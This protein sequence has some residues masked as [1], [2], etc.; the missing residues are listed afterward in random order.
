[1]QLP[2]GITYQQLA[3]FLLVIAVLWRMEQLPKSIAAQLDAYVPNKIA[4]VI[5][6]K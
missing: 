3:I 6:G 1:M 5:K 4:E 2:F